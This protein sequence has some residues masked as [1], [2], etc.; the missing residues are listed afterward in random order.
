MQQRGSWVCAKKL[1]ALTSRRMQHMKKTIGIL[2]AVALSSAAY[3]DV[4]VGGYVDAGYSWVKDGSNAFGVNGAALHVGG[5]SGTT[6]FLVDYNVATSNLDQAYVSNKYD[7]GFGWRLGQF[8]RILGLE[9]TDSTTSKFA[10]AAGVSNGLGLTVNTHTGLLLSYDLSDALGL[11]I[12]VANGDTTGS[13]DYPGMGFRLDS[14]MDGLNAFVGGQFE[15]HTG[16]TAYDLNLGATSSFGDIGLGVELLMS[17]TGV[18]DTASGLAFGLHAD[19]A[20]GEMGVHARL[21]WNNNKLGQPSAASPDATMNLALG[22]S[23][24][25]S[26]ALTFRASYF[27][28]DLSGDPKEHA[29]GLAGVYQ[30]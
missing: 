12:V 28:S 10:S 5:T 8:D 7:S 17:S 1:D 14:K 23:Q 30:F 9:G 18:D 11:H 6:G 4:N 19:Y 29:V 27:L 21:T 15:G 2:S 16:N 25:M 26:E 13:V 3:A 22:V 20:V 24:A